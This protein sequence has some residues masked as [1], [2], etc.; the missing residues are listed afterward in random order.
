MAG[1]GKTTLMQRLNAHV[2][3][4]KIPSYTI[5]LDP[6]VAKLPYGANIDIRDT[7]NYKEVMKQYNLGPNGGIMTSLNLFS[8]RFDQ[9]MSF[10]EKRASTLDYI[11]MD[12]P[13]QI[14]VFTWSASGTIITELMASAFPTVV[15]YVV[16]TPRSLNP[17]TFMSNMLYACSILYKARL[18][19]IVVFN[20]T[21]IT[22][23]DFAVEWMTDFESF[24]DASHTDASYMSTLTR[25]MGLVL[26]E[27]YSNLKAVGVSAVT[28]EGIDEFF[29]AVDNAA[30]EFNRTYKKDRDAKVAKRAM[31]AQSKKNADLARLKKD[32]EETAGRNVLLD[33]TRPKGKPRKPGT[34]DEDDE[35]EEEEEEG[36]EEEEDVHNLDSKLKNTDF[37]NYLHG[38]QK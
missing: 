21:D 16:D 34:E 9:V 7:V 6:A 37:M 33:A 19:L 38:K 20:K 27:F 23:H 18:P 2:H 15:V 26:D 28:G 3:Q 12:T 4:H 13:G 24:Q 8:T 14:E 1:S 32:L 29:E 22:K 36:E 25:S 31:E 35:E 30:E 11:L 5:N 17:T 10:V